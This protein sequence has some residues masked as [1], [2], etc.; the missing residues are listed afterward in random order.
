MLKTSNKLPIRLKLTEVTF[1]ISSTGIIRLL[2]NILNEIPAI[3]D[4]RYR[5]RLLRI[6][7]SFL[8]ISFL[9]GLEA[10]YS[11]ISSRDLS[12]VLLSRFVNE[13][14]INPTPD[15]RA[16]GAILD[17][18]NCINNLAGSTIKQELIN[19]HHTEKY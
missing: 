7:N 11:F 17:C 14:K 3:A 12:I 19:N 6:S 4:L 13:S 18:K 1:I 5:L 2:V 9:S 10:L 16:I 15:I 8:T